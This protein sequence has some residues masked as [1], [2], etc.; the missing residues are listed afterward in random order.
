MN[1]DHQRPDL[2]LHGTLS[3]N[4][5]GFC[6]LLRTQGAGLGPGEELD[7]LHALEQ[8]GVDNR[9]RFRAALRTTLAKNPR[10]QAL[11]DQYFEHY[12]Q[13]WD[14]ASELNKPVP[15]EKT[16]QSANA[17]KQTGTT[18]L[19]I[20]DW[21]KRDETPEEDREAAGYSPFAVVTKRDFADFD[22]TDLDEV[23]RLIAALSKA[24]AT[25]FNRRYQPAK[26]GARIDLR[27]SMRW[28]LKY[29][30]DLID[31]AFRR[32][33]R[34]KL[35]LVLLCDVSKSMDLYSRF[36]IQFVYGFQRAYRRLET[37]AFSTAL[38]RITPVLRQRDLTQVLR[39]LPHA[40]PEWS[41]GTRIGETLREF[42]EQHGHLVDRRTVVLIVSDGW[43]TGE[44][45]LLTEQM[46]QLQR[47]ARCLVWLNPLMGNDTYEPTCR[48]MQAA[49]PFID[50]FA[51]AHNVDSLRQLVGRLG[52]LRNRVWTRAPKAAAPATSAQTAA[53]PSPTQ[54]A[55]APQP[56]RDRQ[57]WRQRFDNASGRLT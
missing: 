19:D 46:R 24:L 36:L 10:E 6:R 11:F 1:S 23:S 43:D 37:F 31:L 53:Q 33:R 17:P 2:A 20:R 51:P 21:L 14:R 50:I 42:T 55:A 56:T 32:R 39:R 26:Q 27:R 12:W 18:P 4:L 47:R 57:Y 45:D 7:A 49:L 8:L 13:V 38:H 5:I 52:S 48:G 16:S 34:Q 22:A 44:V 29:G 30:G 25:R 3:T 28:G 41:G 40:M 35:N 15:Q 9:D 54:P